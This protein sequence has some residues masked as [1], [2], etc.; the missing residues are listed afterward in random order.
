MNASGGRIL[1]WIGLTSAAALAL[2]SLV[3]VSRAEPHQPTKSSIAT[4]H[5][6]VK[7]HGKHYIK[8]K[9]PV[10][11][12]RPVLRIPKARLAPVNYADIEGWAEDNQAAAF[13]TFLASCQAILKGTPALRAR[14]PVYRAL[15][16]ICSKAVL[17]PTL[18]PQAARAFFEQ[19][20]R[21]IRIS[22]AGDPDGFITGYYEP[23]VDG[24][25]KPDDTY[26]YPIYRKPGDLLP[27][28]RMI[29]SIKTILRKGK[30]I[31][32]KL[33]V[34]YYDRARIENGALDGRNLE[35]CYLKDPVDA[36]FA[37]IQGS[38]RVDLGNGSMLRLNYVAAN[39]Q[40]YTAVGKYLIERKIYSRDEMSME[41]IREWMNANPE[42]GRDL[43]RL[44]KS[45]V[46][47]R[48]TG[49][50]ANQEPVGA[51]GVSL[52]PGRSIAV[53]HKLHVYGTPFFIQAKLPI[54]D[55]T[56]TTPFRR[57]MIA[58]DTGGAIVGPARADIY[59]GAG[60]EAGVVSGRFKNPGKFVMLVPKA[61]DPF[62][63]PTAAPVAPLADVPLP[64]PR[65]TFGGVAIRTEQPAVTATAKP[66]PPAQT[67]VTPRSPAP[68]KAEPKAAVAKKVEPKTVESKRLEPAK[69]EPKKIEPKKADLKKTEPKT[70]A[71]KKVEAKKLEAKKTETE[72]RKPEPPSLAARLLSA[73]TGKPTPEQKKAPAK[74][75]PAKPSAAKPA[76]PKGVNPQAA[77]PK[78][79]KTASGP[80]PKS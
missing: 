31:A 39:G 42:G 17:L 47:F 45:Y 6:A 32:K 59:W 70:L 12:E 18:D 3:V 21:P 64:L 57:L 16:D 58:Q 5:Q 68:I 63:G 38:L 35:I 22:P 78:A 19:N 29:G 2:S 34:P 8:S 71:A 72:P 9:R 66:A 51:E 61:V 20:F 79:S 37:H 27:G 56:P 53:D 54:A 41:K 14:R 28:G 7:H 55:E 49:L 10:V 75:T 25:R 60:V 26:A 67:L 44:N 43:R 74:P 52:T 15:Y 33:L 24:R 11:E 50:A 23:I 30:R 1:H 77:A 69:I 13:E 36:F 48:D 62:A 65:P 46:F 4:H 76:Q 80:Q 40:P 73:I